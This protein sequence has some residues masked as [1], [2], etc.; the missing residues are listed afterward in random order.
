MKFIKLIFLFLYLMLQIS[1]TFDQKKTTSLSQSESVEH[2]P[3]RVISNDPSFC[4]E[5]TLSDKID[6]VKIIVCEK[7]F[8]KRP[9]IRPPQDSIPANFSGKN[10]TA[11]IYGGIYRNPAFDT[12]LVDRFGRSFKIIDTKNERHPPG[13]LKAIFKKIKHPSNR[14]LF[15]LYKMTGVISKTEDHYSITDIISIEPVLYLSGE[16][17][18]NHFIGK[19]WEGGYYQQTQ[20]FQYELQAPIRIKTTKTSILSDGL[21]ELSEWSHN[22]IKGAE[23]FNIDGYIENF[24]DNITSSDGKTCLPALEKMDDRSN[25][26]IGATDM[27]IS[28]HRM[29]T[30]HR[31]GDSVVVFEYPKKPGNLPPDNLPPNGMDAENRLLNVINFL[32]IKSNESSPWGQ[33]NVK[34][35]SANK[36]HLIR[37]RPVESDDQGGSRCFN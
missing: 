22:K 30:M 32:Q 24:R 14:M 4:E 18:D 23:V 11:T 33:L 10:T 5:E 3:K 31:D 2:K 21:Q 28:F 16:S 35:H 9:Y 26:F 8:A 36:K 20:S 37:L 29:G 1:C 25:P 6:N 27:N 34:P 15:T 12:T 13:K 7:M 17:I 19:S